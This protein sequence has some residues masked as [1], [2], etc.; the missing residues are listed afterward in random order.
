L[1]FKKSSTPLPPTG[2]MVAC[3]G[4]RILLAALAIRYS[5]FPAIRSEVHDH[6]LLR[7]AE[8][9][10]QPAQLLRRK[11]ILL[12]RGELHEHAAHALVRGDEPHQLAHPRHHDAR[13]LLDLEEAPE[14]RRHDLRGVHRS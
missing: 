8:L 11:P 13:R 4:A 7:V 12:A 14:H 3:G 2:A 10:D 6:V 1:S 5:W 9:P